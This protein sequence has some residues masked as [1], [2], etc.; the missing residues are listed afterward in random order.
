MNWPAPGSE[1]TRF[2]VKISS[3][4]L[5]R[6]DTRRKFTREF[7]LGAVRPTSFGACSAPKISIHGKELAF[8]PCSITAERYEAKLSYAN[9]KALDLTSKFR[10][11]AANAFRSTKHR[12][13]GALRGASRL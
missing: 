8:R 4:T 11:R 10:Y 1:D 13:R 3:S 2:G 6:D 12:L 9:Q 5:G 7:K